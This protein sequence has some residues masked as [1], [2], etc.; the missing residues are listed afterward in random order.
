[1]SL[2][3]ERPWDVLGGGQGLTLVG[4]SISVAR[5]K[6]R[7]QLRRG[8]GPGSQPCKHVSRGNA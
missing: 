7:D 5:M 4:Q 3:R 8:A 2:S 1:M 6:I